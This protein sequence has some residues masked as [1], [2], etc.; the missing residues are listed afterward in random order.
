[1]APYHFVLVH[2]PLALWTTAAL[3]ILLR[4][5]SDGRLAKASDRVLVPLLGLGV[6]FGV[7]AYVVGFLVWPWDTVTASPLARNHFLA[8]TWSLAYWILLL[9]SRWIQGEAIWEGATRWIM[10]GLA[11]LGGT[12]LVVTGTLGGHLAGAPTAVSQVLHFLGW[13]VYTTFYVPDLVLGLFVA[14]SVALLA[15]GLWGRAYRV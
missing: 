7:L 2:F 9:I 10:L 13:E 1:M 14:A 8:A 4:A 11:A 12:L 5:L 15:L 6:L 3:V